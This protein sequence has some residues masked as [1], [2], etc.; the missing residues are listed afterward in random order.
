VSIRCKYF[1]DASLQE[2]LKSDGGDI[3]GFSPK[4]YPRIVFRS[5]L[6]VFRW[7]G[8]SFYGSLY[9]LALQE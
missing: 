9:F 4:I 7:S 6:I 5:Y 8:G 2:F 3:D 1:D